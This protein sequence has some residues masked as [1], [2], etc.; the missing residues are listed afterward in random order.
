MI[1]RA[2]YNVDTGGGWVDDT[3]AAAVTV[4]RGAGDLCVKILQPQTPALGIQGAAAVHFINC[5]PVRGRCLRLEFR[6]S[7][8]AGPRK[9]GDD[10]LRRRCTWDGTLGRRSDDLFAPVHGCTR[11]GDW[12]C[13]GELRFAA[14]GEVTVALCSSGSAPPSPVASPTALI[15]VMTTVIDTPG[16]S[17][18]M[19]NA[20]PVVDA[21]RCRSRSNT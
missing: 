11:S 10:F 5:W 13:G 6:E 1:D 17:G 21:R 16:W 9:G 7:C 4:A 8:G 12:Q 3:Y 19:V 15:S 14:R 2:V 18:P 20:R